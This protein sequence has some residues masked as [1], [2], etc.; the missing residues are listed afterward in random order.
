MTFILHDLHS[1]R[2]DKG[3]KVRLNYAQLSLSLKKN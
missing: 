2:D 1:L 3:G